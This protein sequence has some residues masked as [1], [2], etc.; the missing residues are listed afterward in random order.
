MVGRNGRFREVPMELSFVET[1]TIGKKEEA[2]QERRGRNRDVESVEGV[3]KY[4]KWEPVC[5]SVEHPATRDHPSSI[6][7]K[8]LKS[9]NRF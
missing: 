9:L 2:G 5:R 3:A 1:V 6:T 7:L 4:A 8:S